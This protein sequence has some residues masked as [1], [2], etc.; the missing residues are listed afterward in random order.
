MK[1][2]L[3]SLMFFVNFVMLSGMV[4]GGCGLFCC[5]NKIHKTVNFEYEL[6]NAKY[7][8]KC[9]CCH[10]KLDS[11]NLKCESENKD[12]IYNCTIV[13]TNGNKCKCECTRI[14]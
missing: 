8:C 9:K 12:G 1:K 11:A 13:D 2:K 6:D 3:T 5:K 4:L 10:I 7:R 14:D